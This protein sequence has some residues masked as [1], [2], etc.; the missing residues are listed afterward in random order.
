MS[1]SKFAKQNTT[2]ALDLFR[3]TYGATADKKV[4]LSPFS[5]RRA[6]GMTALGARGETLQGFREAFA[7]AKG[8]SIADFHAAN[9]E[10]A[11]YLLTAE[12]KG[13]CPTE[14]SIANALWL[15]KDD[16]D[17]YVFQQPF[18]AANQQYYGATVRDNLPM[19][20]S[21]LAEINEWCN[22][23]TKGKI[24]KILDQMPDEA[25][26]FLTD[27]LYMKTPA[28]KRFYKRNDTKG[29]FKLAGGSEKDVTFMTNP[30]GK[31]RYFEGDGVEVLQFPFGEHGV[32]NAYIVLPSATSTLDAAVNSLTAD[33]WLGWKAA[34][35]MAEGRLRLAP[36]EQEWGGEMKAA[37]SQMGLSL[38]FSD[39]ADFNDLCTGGIRIGCVKHKT[40]TKFMRK[41][42]EGAAVTLV[43]MMRSTSVR[44]GGPKKTFDVL[45]NRPYAWF[46]EG[47]GDI[48]FAS[49]T[50]DP[51]E[52][53]GF[54]DET[55]EVG[56]E[57]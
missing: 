52:P 44:P 41:G 48:L 21:T 26:A 10:V 43:G 5:I 40:Y 7:L 12:S 33:N 32:F 56:G 37:L 2:F 53:A 54:A 17:G 57:D 22:K 31:F 35:E 20:D 16:G 45:V 1:Q 13:K 42:F 55:D 38:A 15:R 19:D 27:A 50:V 4:Q 46:V 23:N 36:N 3:R 25:Q 9:Q 11:N 24:T 51:K 34:L 14:I 30:H 18:I 49:T 8:D 29:K 39:A 28:A 6:L 47:A